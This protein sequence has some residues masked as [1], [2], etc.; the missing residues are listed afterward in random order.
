MLFDLAFLFP[1]F[2]KR[3]DLRG[4]IYYWLSGESLEYEDEENTDIVAVKQNYISVTPIHYDLTNYDF[5][6]DLGKWNIDIKNKIEV[7]K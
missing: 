5:L 2:E 1:I 4:K 6:N 3:T 7:N